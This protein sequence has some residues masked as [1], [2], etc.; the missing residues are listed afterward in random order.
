[1]ETIVVVDDEIGIRTFL[2][3]ALQDEGYTILEA[4]N[5]HEALSLL[6]TTR[7]DLIISDIMMP[8]MD[9]LTMVRTMRANP[10]ARTIP[11]ILISAALPPPDVASLVSTTFVA[12]PFTLPH[13]LDAITTVMSHPGH[14]LLPPDAPS[15]GPTLSA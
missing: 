4:G 15:D 1:M 7:V 14:A 5:G 9:G 10:Q 3:E 12:K 2:R 6:T 13:L 11:V 8:R